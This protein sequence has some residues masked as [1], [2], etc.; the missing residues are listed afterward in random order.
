MKLS[1]IVPC[2]NEEKNIPLVIGRFNQII[3]RSEVEVILVDNGSTDNSHRIIHSLL[4]E[5]SFVRT[6][7]VESNQGYGFGILSG[8][9]EAKGEYIGWTHADMQTDPYDVIKG[10]NL[11][12]KSAY[13]VKTFIK[14]TR[15]KRPLTD[16][17]FT[18]GM[19]I[20]EKIYLG[21]S[22]ND[23][24]AQ[25]TLFHRS[26][27]ELWDEPPYDFSLDLYAFYMARKH[28]F[29]VLRFP[30]FFTKRIHGHSNWNI[31]FNGKWK[32][33]KRT[34]DFSFALKEKMK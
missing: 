32:L 21:A 15:K 8:L 22:L 11:I 13:P 4:S 10:L 19:E 27:F 2:F 17:F 16:K 6:V 7:K 29:E 30:V 23:I 3:K 24:N 1:V 34:L 33:I 5:Y 28:N 31:G 14:G 25:P 26:F 9:R 20:F 18:W 12:E